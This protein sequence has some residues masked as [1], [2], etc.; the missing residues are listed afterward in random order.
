M[1]NFI[2]HFHLGSEDDEFVN[3]IAHE[4]EMNNDFFCDTK[5]ESLGQAMASMKINFSINTDEAIGL[6]DNYIELKNQLS[7][8]GFSKKSLEDLMEVNR[9]ILNITTKSPNGNTEV[10]H[11]N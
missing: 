7:I 4:Y 9:V 10:S 2:F 5:E 3:S 8:D 1:Y 6:L 11:R